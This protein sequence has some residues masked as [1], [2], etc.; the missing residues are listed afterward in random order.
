[1]VP[2]L[3][4]LVEASVYN[5]RLVVKYYGNVTMQKALE[6]KSKSIGLIAKEDEDKAVL[7]VTNLFRAVAKYFD[8]VLSQEKAEVIATEILYKYEYRNLKL[9]DLVVI[10]IRLKESDIYKLTAARIMREVSKYS[11]E[12][13]KLAVT[14]SIHL[15]E[16]NKNSVNY[17][18][19]ERLQ[20]SF[21]SLPNANKIASKRTA[22]NKKFK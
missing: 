10:C 1:M 4:T 22:I 7:C 13:E 14:R 17:A 21:K 2:A 9:E 3:V 6:S 12:R 20:K 5:N 19:E 11:Q 16:S 18:L 8:N 15:S